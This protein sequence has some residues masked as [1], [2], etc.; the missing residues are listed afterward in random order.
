MIR[1]QTLLEASR[2]LGNVQDAARALDQLMPFGIL[3]PRQLQTCEQ[4]YQAA[5]LPSRAAACRRLRLRLR[6]ESRGALLWP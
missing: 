2:A 3:D 1:L 6:P 5:K 4:V